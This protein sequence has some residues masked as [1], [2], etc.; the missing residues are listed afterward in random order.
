MEK[1]AQKRSLRSKIWEKVNL[2]GRALEAL[3]SEVREV[4]DGMRNVDEEIRVAAENVKSAIRHAKGFLRTRDYLKAAQNVAAFHERIKHVAYLLNKFVKSIDLKHYKFIFEQLGAPG[5]SPLFDYD[6]HAEIKEASELFELIVKEAGPASWAKEKFLNIH[7]ITSGTLANLFTERGRVLRMMEKRFPSSFMRELKTQT[8]NIVSTSERMLQ[9]LLDTFNKLESG[10]SRRNINLYVNEANRFIK[11][12]NDYHKSFINY[13][14]KIVVPLK[15]QYDAM[16][17]EEQ[18][19][20]EK[21]L[22]EHEEKKVIEETKKLEDQVKEQKQMEEVLKGPKPQPEQEPVGN[23]LTDKEPGFDEWKAKQQSLDAL[24][25]LKETHGPEDV[26]AAS[27]QKFIDEIVAY[28]EK[29]DVKSFIDHLLIYS[30]KL[31]ENDPI[32][33]TKLLKI[34]DQLIKDKVAG[35]FD[36][37]KSK[38]SVETTDETVSEQQAKTAPSLSSSKKK[39]EELLEEQKQLY[40]PRKID[41]PVGRVDQALTDVSV[42]Q[43]ITP[44]RVRITPGAERVMI[45]NFVRRL[46]SAKKLEDLTPFINSIENKLASV[47][48]QAIYD[49]WVISNSPA[50]DEFN[51]NDRIFEIYIRF[52]LKNVDPNLT[53]IV[54]MK[55]NCRLSTNNGFF[56]LKDIQKNFTIENLETT[57]KPP[58][59]DIPPAPP[60]KPVTKQLK[61]K[62][63]GNDEHEDEWIDKDYDYP[64]YDTE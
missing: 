36:F 12:F 27:N 26:T 41:L 9:D 30:S 5:T 32:K 22:Q 29:E 63:D 25:K 55:V 39:P 34:A 15:K 47:M 6:P 61:H 24:E 10:V 46:A 54:K 57:A 31:E 60:S 20:H 1:L 14:N 42:L 35:I 58:V 16:T 28:A 18:K 3:N 23:L 48:K 21:M 8:T 52:D 13:H 51:P 53:G 45:A 4:M 49:G 38:Q 17:A 11:K 59:P 19:A 44:G 62:K 37:L 33:S 50:L 56:S 43:S 7:D 40:Q 2:T 64:E